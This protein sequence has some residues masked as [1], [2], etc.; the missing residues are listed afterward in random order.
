M[1]P[2]SPGVN[3]LPVRLIDVFA[4]LMIGFIPS[5]AAILALTW[6]TWASGRMIVVRAVV[7][8]VLL[9][10]GFWYG[11]PF[12]IG[13]ILDMTAQPPPP[14][15]FNAD[16]GMRGFAFITLLFFSAVA[17]L[18]TLSLPLIVVHGLRV[19]NLI[20]EFLTRRIAEYPKGSILAVS[21]LAAGAVALFKALS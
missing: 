6:V 20:G 21:A 7:A 19:A 5:L 1:L 13:P 17:I 15:G 4:M 9:V 11:M 8:V 10:F 3:A 18:V 16:Y 14:G 2:P 12:V